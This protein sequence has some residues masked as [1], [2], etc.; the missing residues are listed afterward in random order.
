M[1][2]RTLLSL[3]CSVPGKYCFILLPPEQPSQA[4][5]SKDEAQEVRPL[6]QIKIRHAL[7]TDEKTRFEK[8]RT[9]K[10]T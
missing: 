8:V 9:T 2:V 3:R 4:Y 1:S 7:L 5:H 10:F 6:L